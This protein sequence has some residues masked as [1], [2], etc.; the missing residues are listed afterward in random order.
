MPEP[1]PEPGPKQMSIGHNPQERCVWLN[2][3]TDTGQRFIAR[4]TP[5]EAREI[6]YS[7][8]RHA[9]RLGPIN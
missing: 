4:F 3:P 1:T 5:D 7:L 8:I 2:L 9:D 6:A